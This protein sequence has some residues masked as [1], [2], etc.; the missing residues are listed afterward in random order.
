MRTQ[1]ETWTRAQLAGLGIESRGPVRT[2]EDRPWAYVGFVD[3]SHGRIW[4]KAPGAG[5]RFEAALIETLS[6]SASDHLLCPLVADRRTGW[7]LA[8]DGG[9]TVQA[10]GGAS[11]D[12]GRVF[13]RIQRASAELVEPLL[14]AG[15]PDRRPFRL[16][17][18][19]DQLTSQS[20]PNRA[21]LRAR[22]HRDLFT[23]FV[24]RL[25]ADEAVGL[26]NH[27][28][29]P[30]HAF[31][32]PPL[33]IF[34]WGDSV[35]GH[36]LSMQLAMKLNLDPTRRAPGSHVEELFD[37]WSCNPQSDVAQAAFVV[38]HLLKVDVWMR[39]PA[40]IALH[41]KVAPYWMSELASLLEGA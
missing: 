3:T 4:C 20:W 32:G 15:V 1:I 18:L 6:T 14:A 5:F 33:K 41:P 23:Q 25:T 7:F 34:D 22:R 13:R 40:A 19:F 21:G 31:A 28:L 39:N 17:P 11:D 29:K 38:E 35:V 2:V 16:L 30:E 10:V 37:I 27:D 8:Y 9:P 26:V 36:P 24:D 12:L